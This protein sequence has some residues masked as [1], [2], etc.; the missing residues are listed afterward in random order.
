VAVLAHGLHM[1]APSC[2]GGLAQRI[3][4]AGGALVSEYAFGQPAQAG[5][6]VQRDRIQAGMAR[7]V[8]MIQSCLNGGSLH[9]SRAGLLY[10][11]WLIIPYPT[12]RDVEQNRSAVEANLILSNA[13]DEK[14][15]SVLKC[16]SKDLERI[17]IL[18][19]RDDY[20]RMIEMVEA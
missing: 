6:Y 9:A 8:V 2:N 17:I 16:E 1:V 5:Q 7:A 12:Q 15:I 10:G 20:S 14:V 4:D 3:I 11:R 19:G 13:D 18:N